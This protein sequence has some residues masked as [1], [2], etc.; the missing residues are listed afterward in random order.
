[1]QLN[2]WGIFF[3]HTVV[4]AVPTLGQKTEIGYSSLDVSDTMG[5]LH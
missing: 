5:P 4:E 1:M 2:L 3:T